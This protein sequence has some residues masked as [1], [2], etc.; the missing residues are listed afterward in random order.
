MAAF[1]GLVAGF[2]HIWWPA[3]VTMVGAALI[4]AGV[5]SAGFVRLEGLQL[6]PES[7]RV[8]AKQLGDL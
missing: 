3:G 7:G 4:A 6:H 1:V 2:W 8:G 5:H